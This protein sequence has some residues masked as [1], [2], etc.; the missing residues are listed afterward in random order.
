M[1]TTLSEKG[2]KCRVCTHPNREQIESLLVGS[3]CIAALKPLMSG[4]LSRRALYRHR[5][6]HMVAAGS[7]VARPVAFRSIV[8]KL[9]WL[10][11]AVEYTAALAECRDDSNAELKALQELGR[12]IWLEFRLR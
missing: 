8:Q 9:K 4:A 11:R 1:Q 5:A 3:A 12:L 2:L 7:R 6:E 10:Q